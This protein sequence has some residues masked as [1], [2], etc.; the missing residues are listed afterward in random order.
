VL[1]HPVVLAALGVLVVNDH[2]AKAA[3]PSTA[4]GK[5]SDA[6]GAI[7]LTALGCSGLAAWRRH[8]VR[9]AG[10]LAV[11]ASVVGLVVVVKATGPGNVAGAW[12]AGLARWPID[13]LGALVRGTAPPVP[14]PASMVADPTDALAATAALAVAG[15]VALDHRP[16]R[17]TGIRAPGRRGDDPQ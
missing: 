9:P 10:A 14:A 4:T 1:V 8:P 13:A 12:A 17:R 6:A 16:S 7:V 3:I 5:A 2:W 11:A 15:L